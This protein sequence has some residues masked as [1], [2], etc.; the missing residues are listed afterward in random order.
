MNYSQNYNYNNASYPYNRQQQQSGRQNQRQQSQQGRQNQQGQQR[1]FMQR[2][3]VNQQIQNYNPQQGGQ[4]QGSQMQGRQMQG[5]LQGRQQQGMQQHGGQ[6][7]NIPQL[8]F[9][10]SQPLPD[11]VTMQTMSGEP[12]ANLQAIANM[13][14]SQ[15]PVQQGQEVQNQMNQSQMN[16]SQMN[17]QQGQFNPQQ[18]FDNQNQFNPQQLPQN[19]GQFNQQQMFPQ[20]QNGASQQQN[21]LPPQTGISMPQQ[22]GLPGL[23]GETSQS[24][25][26]VSAPGLAAEDNVIKFKP[27]QTCMQ[28]ERNSA[29]FYE[30]LSKIAPTEYSKSLIQNIKARCEKRQKTLFNLHKDLGGQEYTPKE[31][32]IR[33]A[34][35]FYDGLLIAI[36]EESAT[37]KE[38]SELIESVENDK[39]LRK[40]YSQVADRVSQLYTLQYLLALQM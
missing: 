12:L 2:Q 30:D 5:N 20:M 16:Q 37:M 13:Q 1:Q 10:L 29:L 14:A 3:Y 19:Q 40:L 34:R 25:I 31:S 8:G 15:N 11:G 7:G 9:D 32:K 38:L 4:M 27:L 21:M 18:Q 26:P 28:N 6:G 24:Q 33:K 22:G 39:F 23:T 17:M 36:Y 35:S